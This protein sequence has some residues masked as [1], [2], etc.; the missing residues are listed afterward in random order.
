ME[1]P[2][3]TTQNIPEEPI[4]KDPK[5]KLPEKDKEP[6][7]QIALKKVR[8]GFGVQIYETEEDDQCKKYEGQWE[9]DKRQGFG[10]CLYANGSNYTGYFKNDLR[11]G[12][13]KMVWEEGWEYDGVWREGRL[14]GKGNFRTLE[15][16]LFL[17]EIF[18]ENMI[19]MMSCQEL[20]KIITLLM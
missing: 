17:F 16:F 1:N 10:Y 13:G 5:N 4:Q 9:K 20:S 7:P 2:N 19:R 15:V 14:F 3:D 11:E 18:L 12:H 8:H 6:P